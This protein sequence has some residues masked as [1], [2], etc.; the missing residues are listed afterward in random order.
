MSFQRICLVLIKMSGHIQKWV[1][2]A[3]MWLSKP[4]IICNSVL[5][6]K[7]KEYK[8]LSKKK[9]RFITCWYFHCPISGRKRKCIMWG[10][11]QHKKTELCS[12]HQGLSTVWEVA[13][14]HRLHQIHDW[15]WTLDTGSH[16]S[17]LLIANSK[18]WSIS[19]TASLLET[20][21]I[22]TL[23]TC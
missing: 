15:Q 9:I 18:N 20:L 3:K 7:H 17:Y 22:C 16:G 2:N 12:Q 14:H 19:I 4:K 21:C 13:R 1:V 23:Y 11:Y 6:L 8:S 5:D 10:F